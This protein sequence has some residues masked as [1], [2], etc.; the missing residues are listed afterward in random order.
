MGKKVALGI[1][2]TSVILSAG[3]TVGG[4]G[5][6]GLGN[7][8]SALPTMGTIGGAGMALSELKKLGRKR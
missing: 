5:A 2:K 6:A 1:M 4:S 3:S 7:M 8:A